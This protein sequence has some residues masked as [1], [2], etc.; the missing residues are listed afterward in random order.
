MI[1]CALYLAPDG[2][3]SQQLSVEQIKNALASGEGLLW[4]DTQDVASEERQLLLEVFHFHPLAVED[5]VS[6]DI[7]SPKVD[8]FEDHLFIIVHGINYHAE[9]DVVETTELALFVGKNYMVTNHDVPLRSVDSVLERVQVDGRLMRRGA[10]F[11]AHDLLDALVDDIMPTIDGLMEKGT[12]IEA[13]VLQ[14]PRRETLASI[15]QHKRSILALQRVMAPQREI[16]NSL[17]RGDYPVISG[18]A[19]IYYR[20]IYDHLVR[21]EIL[22]Q[23]LRDLVEG[24]LNTYLSSVSNRLGEVM[25]V[26]SIVAAIFLPLALI[27]G[28]YGMNF[29]NMPELEWRYGYFVVWGVMAG[30]AIALLAYFKRRKWL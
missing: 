13:E 20:N 19:Q 8:E 29:A 15:M 18:R 9:S 24:A 6:K 12:D 26:M 14:N 10:D 22:T 30:V 11:L 4:L 3:L 27:A 2:K 17:S 25:K 7:H 23:N 28:I 5:C 21:I 16:M 1:R